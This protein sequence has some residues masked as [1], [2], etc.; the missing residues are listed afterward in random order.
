[1]SFPFLMAKL[2]ADYYALLSALAPMLMN[3]KPFP[4]KRFAINAR[5]QACDFFE[6]TVEMGVILETQA[7]GYF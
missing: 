5:A 6:D 7:M 2:R 3:F 4:G 1:M